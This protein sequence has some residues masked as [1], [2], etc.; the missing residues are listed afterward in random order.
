MLVHFFIIKIIYTLN[1]RMW[2]K[3]WQSEQ[4]LAIHLTNIKKVF[5]FS[6]SEPAQCKRKGDED[7]I[8]WGVKI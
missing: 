2:N 3:E 1:K 7:V 8:A 5:F 6:M 4:C